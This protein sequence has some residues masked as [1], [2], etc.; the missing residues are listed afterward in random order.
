MC[1]ITQDRPILN[2]S[3]Y[4]FV[5]LNDAAALRESMRSRAHALGLRGTVILADEGVNLAL[6]GARAA[7]QSF[8]DEL[9]RDS[10]LSGIDWKTSESDALPF[11]R[12][13]F[14][15]KR[16]IIRMNQPLVRP[17]QRRAPSIAPSTLA[18]WLEEGCDEQG[19]EVVMLD[20]RN[21]FEVDQGRFRSALDWR[22]ARFSDFPL[23]F[24]QRRAELA[25]KTVVSYCT[26]GIRCEKAA[27]WM[28]REGVPNVLQLDGGILKYLEDEGSRYF[29]GSCFVFDQR[30]ALDAALAPVAAL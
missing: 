3:G 21:G 15:L 27:L 24:A 8:I 14:K 5:E 17:Q 4:R 28:Q 30:Q 22:L 12:L 2:V 16:E 18:R 29:E 19:H 9:C 13:V 20:A 26:G 7:L 6:A 11:G 1:V 10:R 23:A 25:G